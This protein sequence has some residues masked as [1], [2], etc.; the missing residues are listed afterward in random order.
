MVGLNAGVLCLKTTPA[1]ISWRKYL[2]SGPRLLYHG[3]T[4][5]HVNLSASF[6][7]QEMFQI[8]ES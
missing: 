5:W 8:A 3:L 1:V 7:M 6:L 2:I 4:E